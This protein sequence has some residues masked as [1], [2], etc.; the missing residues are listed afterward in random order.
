MQRNIK[1][2]GF[3]VSSE[4]K[5]PGL[6][7]CSNNLSAQNH[8]CVQSKTSAEGQ[9]WEKCS[10]KH[11]QCPAAIAKYLKGET[12]KREAEHKAAN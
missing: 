11:L 3:A 12:S 10:S 7:N 2:P 8:G 1:H 5:D 6:E 9:R 4:R